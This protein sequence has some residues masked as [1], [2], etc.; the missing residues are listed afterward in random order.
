MSTRNGYKNG[1]GVL[2]GGTKLDETPRERLITALSV[3][4]TTEQ[5]S[6]F[7]DALDAYLEEG[8]GNSVLTLPNLTPNYSKERDTLRR[9]RD[10]ALARAEKAK[11]ALLEA[12]EEMKV[13]VDAAM[14]KEDGK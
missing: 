1:G 6:D 9:E 3:S 2:F 12:L 11:Q 4:M 10:E 7:A 8:P 5:A 13:L 14:D